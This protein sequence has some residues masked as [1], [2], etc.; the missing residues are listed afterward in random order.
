MLGLT[1][2]DHG[3]S[4]ISIDGTS[5]GTMDWNSVSLTHN[6][7]KSLSTGA[8]T[9]GYHRVNIKMHTK[10]GTNYYFSAIKYWIVPASD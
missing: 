6:V 5:I 10:T 2:S 4:T 8:L 9:A 7:L 1:N 3:I